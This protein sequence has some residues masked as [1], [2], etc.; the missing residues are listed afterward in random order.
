VSIATQ[1]PTFDD[2][3]PLYPDDRMFLFIPTIT[4]ICGVPIGCLTQPLPGVL[5]G[6]HPKGTC[7]YSDRLFRFHALPVV[8]TLMREE[9]L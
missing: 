8:G 4:C 2:I 1:S 3:K 7:V 6:R 9:S 5:Y